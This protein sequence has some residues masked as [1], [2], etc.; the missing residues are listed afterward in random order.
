LRQRCLKYLQRDVSHFK[1]LTDDNSQRNLDLLAYTYVHGI[2]QEPK[3]ESLIRE[4]ISHYLACKFSV[5]SKNEK[6]ASL[7]KSN[8]QISSDLIMAMAEWGH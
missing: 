5:L 7:L 1:E 2:S 4:L 3:A 8:P 6:F